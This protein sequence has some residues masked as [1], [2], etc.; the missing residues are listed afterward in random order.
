MSFDGDLEHLPI[1][2]VIQLLH[3]TGKS[4]TL[5][6]RSLKGESQLVFHNG[7]IVSANHVNNSVRIGQILL[8]MGKISEQ[9]LDSALHE[10]Q[11]AGSHRK[12]IIQTMIEGGRVQTEA[13]YQGLEALIEMTIV[14]ILTWTK[15]TFSL[16]VNK[17]F[18]SDEYR[19][20]PEQLKKEI[21]LN[22]QSVLMDALRIYDERKR[23]GTLTI[24]AMFGPARNVVS[25]ESDAEISDADLGLDA[26][27][28]LE[29][30]IPQV[31]TGLSAFEPDSP[32]RR[33]QQVL[34]GV[35]AEEQQRLL[36]Y[37][38]GVT[39]APQA[40]GDGT[41]VILVTGDKLV[42]ECVSAVCGP[43]F[44]LA[45]DDAAGVD[46]I[47]DH[48]LSKGRVP[49]LLLDAGE[50][51]SR[52]SAREGL[53]ALLQQKREKY[54]ELAVVLL[55]CPGDYQLNVRALQTGISAVLP[56]SSR[57]ERPE[58]FAADTIECT[59]A[60]DRYLKEARTEPGQGLLQQF[61]RQFLALA[62]QREPAEV[63]F[64]L[65]QAISAFFDRV[66]TLVLVRSELIAERGIGI[67]EAGATS[68][69]KLRIPISEPSL[70]QQVLAGESY[71]GNADPLLRA[72][73][74]DTIGTP[75]SP[76]VLLL[77]VKSFGRV[78]AL[79]YGDFGARAGG[80]PRAE[81]LEILALH[82]G[83]VIDNVLYRKRCAQK[84]G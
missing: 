37:L 66:V 48:S 4:G 19:Y 54:P 71:Y 56:R 81:L 3:A 28:D 44:L 40:P 58:S 2:D 50:P 38:E 67:S 18:V 34:A 29:R 14:E 47:I 25:R 51:S 1:V 26:L 75:A 17:I 70:F 13:A 49:L 22:T 62:E 6:L 77:P 45:T 27:D 80:A 8:D 16:D 10:Q 64:L 35:P 46:P 52:G 5:T 57:E 15:G 39:A 65:L 60:L 84:A 36:S 7:Y 41:G 23:D 24:E 21:Q 9:E 32:S 69:V 30:V 43:H 63:T 74:F 42:R 31:F 68:T 82:A 73:L 53:V 61:K 79:I 78:I 72:T 59:R 83:L 12:P 55:T 33:L 20:F 11:R 76:K